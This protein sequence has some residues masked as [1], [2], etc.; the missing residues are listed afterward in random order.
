MARN[1][2]TNR[3]K[4]RAERIE[5]DKRNIITGKKDLTPFNVGRNPRA[6]SYK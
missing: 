1:R 5:L 2:E 6:Y 3:A 4:V